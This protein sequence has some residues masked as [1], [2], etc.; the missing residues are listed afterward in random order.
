MDKISG[1]QAQE[2]LKVAAQNV[3]SLSKDNQELVTQRDG[4]L[5][6]IAHFEKKERAEKIAN[7][8]EEKGVQTELSFSEKVASLLSGERDLAVVEEALHMGA[9]QIK[10]ASVD[11]D[12]N[13][14]VPGA[15]D[16]EGQA[17]AANFLAALVD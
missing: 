11:E 5:S 3:R 16:T 9:P 8:M 10:V 15:D 1:A 2:L 6:K 17:A 12:S 4:L 13:V 14:A 7:L